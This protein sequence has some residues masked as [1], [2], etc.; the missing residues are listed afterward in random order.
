MAAAAAEASGCQ[1]CSPG[2]GDVGA[3]GCGQ[4]KQEPGDEDEAGRTVVTIQS[5]R[6]I[7]YLKLQDWRRVGLTAWGTLGKARS[8]V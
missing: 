3:E 5:S 6:A 2:G 1:N 4:W 7:P 8:S